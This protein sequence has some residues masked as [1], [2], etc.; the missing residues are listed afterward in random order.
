MALFIEYSLA[1]QEV[2]GSI[3]GWDTSFS[4]TLWKGCRWLWSSLYKTTFKGVSIF[5]HTSVKFHFP[6]IV[7]DT[8]IPA[9]RKHQHRLI[10][11]LFMPP[12]A[13]HLSICDLRSGCRHF[14]LLSLWSRSLVPVQLCTPQRLRAVNPLTIYR[15]RNLFVLYRNCARDL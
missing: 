13:Q 10:L 6:S 12:M 4:D 7:L 3:P 14:L 8:D 15:N 2:P 11:Y 9:I 5:M 1:V